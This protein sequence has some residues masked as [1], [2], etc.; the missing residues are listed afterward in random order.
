MSLLTDALDRI[1]TWLVKNQPEFAL[2]LQPGLT[3]A[4]IDTILQN[5][6]YAM[7]EELYEFY[8]WHNGC[9]YLSYGYVIPFYDNF[10]SLQDAMEYRQ[11]ALSWDSEWN[12]HWL[13]ILD[14]NGDYRY[15]V[16]VGEETAPVWFIDPE[17]GIKEIRWDSLTDLMLATAECY[18]TGAYYIDNEGYIEEDKPKI[19]EIRRKYNYC[20]VETT[21]NE[22]Y[23]PEPPTVASEVDLS[24]PNALEELT[25]A[26]Q[27]APLSPEA[28][29]L[30]AM[31]A[32]TLKNLANLGLAG[33]VGAESLT[34][35]LQNIIY[36][37]AGHALAAKKL[38]ELGDPRAVEPLLQALTHPSSEVRRNAIE[39]LAKLGDSRAIE[40]LIQCLQD[41]DFFV[42]GQAAWALAEIGDI[43]AIEPL[44]QALRNENQSTTCCAIASALGK[45]ADVRAIEPLIEI[46]R[47]NGSHL[48]DASSF[49]HVRLAVIQALR[50][51]DDSRTTDILVEFL[52]D[53]EG[54]LQA[55]KRDWLRT[56][57]ATH[58]VIETLFTRQ[59]PDLIEILTQLLQDSENQIQNNILSAIAEIANPLLVDLLIL[60]LANENGW[61]RQSAISHLGRRGDKRAVEPLINILQDVDTDVRL[62]AVYALQKMDDV[63][64]VNA[65]IKMLKDEDFRV[66]GATALAL[67]N[68][69]N[70]SA[71]EPLNQCLED[72]SSIVRKIV[73][74]ALN[75]LS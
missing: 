10:F 26:L 57:Q 3:N 8:G 36:D 33:Q 25:Q 58:Q 74:E 67:G 63:R 56:E 49:P 23:N 2:S 9:R 48:R 71:V 72:E 55:I 66:R 21:T 24:N 11:N 59:H 70:L 65:L 44:S 54:M 19:A 17:C 51:I 39:S 22:S 53:R 60:A 20:V 12:S 1:E 46:F 47:S 69:G 4:E 18:E 42:R 52:R 35:S 13:P 15:A 62:A 5:F 45:F 68:L 29:V 75:K 50:L 31:A 32:K 30:Q 27:A 14:G 37:N 28:G 34:I 61:L 7:P 73:Q 41:S 43:K 40:P 6:P 16:V 64:V 38:G